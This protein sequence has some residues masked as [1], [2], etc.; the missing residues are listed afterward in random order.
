MSTYNIRAVETRRW[1]GDEPVIRYWLARECDWLQGRFSTLHDAVC[2]HQA[3]RRDDNRR[4]YGEWLGIA[5]IAALVVGILVGWPIPSA[6]GAVPAK[7]GCHIITQL[8]HVDGLDTETPAEIRAAKAAVEL[9]A[10]VTADDVEVAFHDRT[11]S[12]MTGGADKRRPEDLTFAEL[13]SIE[14]IGGRHV[15]T[16]EAALRAAPGR[17]LIEV[18]D[19]PT[20]KA[21]WDR[22]GLPGI[23]SLLV[24]LKMRKRTY[25]GSATAT[26]VVSERFHDLQVFRRTHRAADLTVAHIRNKGWDLVALSSNLYSKRNVA[27]VR[28]AGA[29][30]A[31]RN[32]TSYRQFRAAYD[33]RIVFFQMSKKTTM[34]AYCARARKAA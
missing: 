31:T 25:V 24:Q 14:L 2:E 29:I 12:R 34:Q 22:V 16:L 15:P 8:A 30:P 19:Y 13:S 21:R 4:H 26:A 3:R 33:A 27:T 20:W 6:H 11:L 10:R 1:E 5:L 9:N 28:K 32:V 7:H 17:V 23:R 18:K